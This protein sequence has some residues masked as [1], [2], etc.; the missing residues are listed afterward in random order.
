MDGEKEW[1]PT[2]SLRDARQLAAF[3]AEVPP[4]FSL[5]S[6]PHMS[7]FQVE[8]RSYLLGGMH[9]SLPPDEPFVGKIQNHKAN[10]C[11]ETKNRITACRT[12]I[13]QMGD[14]ARIDQGRETVSKVNFDILRESPVVDIRTWD[15][16]TAFLTKTQTKNPV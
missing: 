15:G 1:Q 10:P 12:A 11:D 2:C 6:P 16:R 9:H 4:P 14:R 13:A 7:G 5:G 3:S 8:I